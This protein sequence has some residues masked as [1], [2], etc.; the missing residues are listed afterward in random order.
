MRTPPLKTYIPIALS[1]ILAL[2]GVSSCANNTQ[3]VADKSAEAAPAAPS[4]K[5]AVKR[6]STKAVE[7]TSKT[8]SS[9]ERA[10]DIAA[11]ATLISNSA[12]SR[13][14]WN[15]AVNSWKEAIG[16]LKT[17]PG[18]SRDRATAQKK[19]S[20]YQS[21]LADAKLKAAPPPA[22]VCSG[23]TNPQFFS[24][25]IKGRV[26]GTPV[27]EVNFNDQQKFE[28][29]FDTGASHTLITRSIAATLGLPPVGSAKIRI[30]NGS[31]VVLP[32]ALVKS[33]EIDGRVKRDIPVAVAPPAMPIGL[34]GQDFY[35][36]YDVI[37]KENIIEF[38]RQN[39]AANKKAVKP[40]PCLVDTTPQFFSAPIKT[41]KM[42]IPVVEVT[43]NDKQKFPMIF[44]TGATKTLITQPMAAKLKLQ[45]L[46]TTEATI[47]DGSV[48]KFDVA[49]VKSNKIANRIKRDVLV[50]VAP[51]G[52]DVGLLGQDFY[53][54]YN[55]TIKENVIEFRR[56]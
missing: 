42:G 43:F 3:I 12:V 29:I 54:G 25:P 33:N 8:I 36:G 27:V 6:V 41:R 37:I 28:M 4:A 5:V 21:Y 47:A 15:L 34:L 32:I 56:Q 19:L 2:G 53:E 18:W 7:P 13:Q 16:L 11:G 22:K 23:D 26:G 1:S 51:A 49:L 10:L 31:V 14:D 24:V 48:A 55:I 9:Y 38:H 20:Q 50:S 40:K 17:V 39:S 45:R 44:D 35:K 30:A 52:M 46:G